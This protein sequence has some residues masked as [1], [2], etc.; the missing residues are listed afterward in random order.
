MVAS[1]DGSE[2][3]LQAAIRAY[4]FTNAA[5]S[6]PKA[7]QSVRKILQACKYD[8]DLVDAALLCTSELVT[9]AVMHAATA[10]TFTVICK[11]RID[12]MTIGVIDRDPGLP[13]KLDTCEDNDFG[14]GLLLVESLSDE[15]GVETRRHGKMVFARL[16]V[17]APHHAGAL[18]EHEPA[19][20]I[21]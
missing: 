7:R 16:K 11:L 18:H 20:C 5:E 17:I 10:P 13:R 15:W 2:V 3:T 4:T 9:N 6:V 12:M 1:L 19:P 21:R 8:S 14:R